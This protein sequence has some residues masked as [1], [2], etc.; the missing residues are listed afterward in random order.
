LYA[1]FADSIPFDALFVRNFVGW[2]KWVLLLFLKADVTNVKIFMIDFF[3]ADL[4]VE[5][6][7][8]TDAVLMSMDRKVTLQV[9]K[10]KIIF[11]DVDGV[12][13]NRA[14]CRKGFG[15]VDPI[16][17]SRL[18]GLIEKS[19]AE[20]VV[21]SCWRMGNV[22]NVSLRELVNEKWGIKGIVLDKTPRL[23]SDVRGDEI[24]DWLDQRHQ[25]RGD[26]ESFVIL[27]DDADMADLLDRLVQTSFEHGLTDI[28]VLQAL[29]ILKIP[30]IPQA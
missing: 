4:A 27:D 14:S 7:H 16:C 9:P 29:E 28:D 17:V 1:P 11:L 5:I 3:Y 18:N 22:H 6:P 21:S 13:I 20:L 24:K 23:P 15:I 2:L 12:I 30:W 25:R 26:I 10:K 19:G 8:D